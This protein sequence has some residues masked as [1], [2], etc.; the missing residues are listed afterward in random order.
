MVVKKSFNS[1]IIFLIPGTYAQCN[2]HVPASSLVSKNP[3]VSI[4]EIHP[5]NVS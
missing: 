5:L 4:F 1:T 2:A 3:K